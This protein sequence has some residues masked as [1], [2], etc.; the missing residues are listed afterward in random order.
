MYLWPVQD[1]SLAAKAAML[2]QLDTLKARY[3][4]AL[5]TRKKSEYEIEALRPV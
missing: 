4:E 3:N 5:E 2:G 1:L